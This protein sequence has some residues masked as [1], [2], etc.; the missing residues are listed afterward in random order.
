VRVTLFGLNPHL[1]PLGARRLRRPQG[2]PL[3]GSRGFTS[4]G[5]P[6]SEEPGRMVAVEHPDPPEEAQ[7]QNQRT[8]MT[9]GARTVAVAEHE[10]IIQR[11]LNKLCQIEVLRQRVQQ[12]CE[13]DA[14][15]REK[16]GREDEL[17]AAPG[18]SSRSSGSSI[19]SAANRAREPSE[20]RGAVR[21]RRTAAAADRAREPAAAA[22]HAR[23]YQPAR[24]A[25]LRPRA[26][27]RGAVSSRAAATS[28][29]RRK[30]ASR[31]TEPAS[32]RAA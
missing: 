23:A 19:R 10:V 8:G 21:P 31:S 4:A 28:A 22:R 17:L 26:A 30:D 13:L 27:A 9:Q 14:A 25:V 15:Q 6:L 16:L 5:R 11:L 20:T 32:A 7:N 2:R 3:G 29:A 12:G 1:R 18:S 24:G